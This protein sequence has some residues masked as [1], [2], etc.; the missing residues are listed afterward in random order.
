[1]CL[2]RIMMGW[3]CVDKKSQSTKRTLHKPTPVTVGSRAY[4][5][6]HEKC[7]FVFLR[8]GSF[9]LQPSC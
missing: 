2:N 4:M 3:G 5:R 6:C 9:V 8:L 1:M 7:M